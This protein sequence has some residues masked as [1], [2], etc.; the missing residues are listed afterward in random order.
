MQHGFGW[1][2]SCLVLMV[3]LGGAATA[4]AQE[5]A[6]RGFVTDQSDGRAL[7]GANVI[8]RQG[9]ATRGAVTD[10]DGSFLIAGLEP[11]RYA[12][13]VSFVGYQTYTDTLELEPDV[14]QTVSVAL[15]PVEEALD[16]VTVEEEREAGAVSQEAGHQQVQ[17]ED[18]E[19]VPSP[20]PSSD[21]ATYLTTQP[22]IVSLA[23]RGG[24]LYIRGGEPSQNRVQI[25][26]MPVY[27]PFHVLGFYS[28]F[29]ADI[30]N[31][32]DI[33]VGGYGAQL[34]GGLSSVID[35]HARRGNT[36]QLEGAA[37]VSPFVSSLRLEGPVLSDRVSFIGSVRQSVIEEGAAR[38]IDEPL[39][40][41]FNDAF[42]K[43][44]GDI[45]STKRLSVAG[46]WTYDRGTLGSSLGS[47][48][49]EVRWRNR[50]VGARY[51]L[52]PRLLPVKT[53]FLV[54]VSELE[55]EMGPSDEPTRQSRIRTTRAGV[56]AT[57]PG[58]HYRVDAGLTGDFVKVS[59]ELGGLYQNI[60]V[61]R[62]PFL[63]QI[64][65]YLAPVFE[66]QEGLRIRPGV[67][68]QFYRVR[69]DPYLEPRLRV[70]WE[71]GPHRFSGGAGLY[72][73]EVVGLSDRRDAANIFTAW[74]NVPR[75]RDRVEDVRAGRIGRAIHTLLGYRVQPASGLTFSLEG[76]YRHLSNLFVA[77]WTGFPRLTTALQPA[78]GRSFGVDLRLE[79]ER[80]PFYG[81]VNYGYSNTLYSAE[82][83]NLEL[84]YGQ[85]DLRFRPP[86]DR[87][88][89]VNALA[90]A[91]F[92]G[93]EAS[94]RWSFG[95]GRPYTRP[96]AFD[97]FY[98]VDDIE[99]ISE[100]SGTR[101][102]IYG[103][104]FNGILPTYHRLD[105]SV[106]RT[107]TLGAHLELT[108]QA[109]VINVYDRDNV[110]YFDTF[111]LHRVDQLPRIPSLGLEVHFQ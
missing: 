66:V 1:S 51:V 31:W 19:R 50:A 45:T 30:I 32:T 90:S 100:E 25:D 61:E 95:S 36:K 58:E 81:F 10:K 38:Y 20:G 56:K 87:R 79:G 33:Y 46:L 75:P 63:N 67:R 110:F 62:P 96:I 102:V 78:S 23:D 18:L 11:G 104:P 77:E 28:A 64:A 7:I 84:W 6:I 8:L 86:H 65:L 92:Y 37:S 3:L 22:G 40:L 44:T 21:L 14:S 52:L 72:Q 17:A 29:P 68:M 69:F 76:Y 4:H 49:T 80:G 13:R 105:A 24:Q 103:R 97:G 82:G 88:H 9:E 93:F 2:I 41:A 71:W 39:P 26:G 54:S 57:F 60:S 99:D 106:E 98:L 109:S 74:T 15:E 43:L 12:L 35:V 94:L 89:Q 83:E 73:Q 42:F 5:A 101:R 34:H 107:F 59:S 70:V 111:T 55:T 27:N 16:E 47:T 91:S 85:E 108:A 53:D 48:L